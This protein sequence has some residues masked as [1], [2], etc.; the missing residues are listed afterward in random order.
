MR[1]EKEILSKIHEIE[2]MLNDNISYKKREIINAILNVLENNLEYD[3]IEEIYFDENK[4]DRESS[5]ND[6]RSWLDG[7]INELSF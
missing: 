3:E 7:D 5:A 1:T 6:A 2:A 4:T